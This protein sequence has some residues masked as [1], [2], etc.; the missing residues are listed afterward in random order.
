VLLVRPAGRRL[1]RHRLEAHQP[2]QALDLLPV[3]RLGPGLRR[4]RSPGLRGARPPAP[5]IHRDQHPRRQLPAQGETP[6]RSKHHASPDASARHPCAPVSGANR[7]DPRAAPGPDRPSWGILARRPASI[8]GGDPRTRPRAGADPRGVNSRCSLGGHFSVL[9][10]TLPDGR[11]TIARSSDNAQF[12]SPGASH[13]NKW[14]YS[15]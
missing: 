2:H 13:R 6:S 7:V 11:K 5:P 15:Y 4:R 3:R 14:T 1:R 10:D 12:T 8:E 9:V